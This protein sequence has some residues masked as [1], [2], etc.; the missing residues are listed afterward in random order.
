MSPPLPPLRQTVGSA[1]VTG[2][3]W[4]ALVA[5]TSLGI[6]DMER[7]RAEISTD[8]VFAA[9]AERHGALRLV[10]QVYAP[11]DL[12]SADKPRPGARALGSSQRAITR[13]ELAAGVTVD[14][15]DLSGVSSHERALVAWVEPGAPD[16]EHDGLG[17]VPPGRAVVTRLTGSAA[18]LRV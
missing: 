18:Q 8:Q 14:V 12:D 6:A 1:A 5:A 17:A 3:S 7:V 2:V 4:L 9:D 13:E 15:L 10:V 16:L 11:K